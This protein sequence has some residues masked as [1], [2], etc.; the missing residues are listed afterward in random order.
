MNENPQDVITPSGRIVQG[1]CFKPKTKDAKGNP[2][3]DKQGVPYVEYFTALAIPKNDPEWPALWALISAPVRAKWPHYFDAQ[4]NPVPNVQFSFKVRDGDAPENVAKEGFAGCWVIG[5]RSRQPPS[6]GSKMSGAW[7]EL[8]TQD[9]ITRGSFARVCIGIKC[10]DTDTN[11]GVYL[12]WYS[13]EVTGYGP[14]IAGGPDAEST[15][16][17][18]APAQLPAGA[19]ATPVAAGGM[20]GTAAQALA[21]VPPQ[22]GPGAAAQAG[23]GVKPNHNFVETAGQPAGHT[24]PPPPSSAP[25]T[26]ALRYVHGGVTYTREQLIAAKWS[27]EAINGLEKRHDVPV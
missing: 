13:L 4:G 18:A 17:A 3:I 19:S 21:P 24:A 25:D 11:P 5:V 10:N 26:V 1:D 14:V 27:E 20:S 8:V 22:A 6:C 9:S 23:L 16:A 12:N 7:V 2:L 15:F